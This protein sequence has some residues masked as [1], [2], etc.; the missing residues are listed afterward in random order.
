MS[1]LEFTVLL[2]VAT[3]IVAYVSVKIELWWAK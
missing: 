3:S 1:W 2:L